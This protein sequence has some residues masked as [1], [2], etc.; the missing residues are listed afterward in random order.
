M[1]ASIPKS[2]PGIDQLLVDSALQP[3]LRRRLL[4]SPDEVFQ[5][6]DLGEYEKEIL[7]K[8]DHRL[9]E[10]LGVALAHQKESGHSSTEEPAEVIETHSPIEAQTLPDTLVAL[11]VVPCFLRESGR[12]TYV[13]W[14]NPMT[15]GSDPAS[16]PQPAAGA[17]PGEPRAP[18]HSVI[19]ISAS[20]SQDAAGNLQVGLWASFRKSSNVAAPPPPETAGEPEC[21]PFGSS[22]DSVEVK[23]AVA[24]VRSA[25]QEERYGKLVDLMRVVRR[26]DVR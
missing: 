25:S 6:F 16:L 19:Q 26:G 12:I 20:P 14:V 5:D 8:P 7:R 11:T 21:S 18:L 4:E 23:A 3:E 24:A 9:L 15:E 10:L 1:A 17:L 13:V 22:L 2:K